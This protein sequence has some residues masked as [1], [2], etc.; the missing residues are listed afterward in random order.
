MKNV[1]DTVKKPV[2]GLDDGRAKQKA[3]TRIPPKHD[4]PARWVPWKPER[5][6]PGKGMRTK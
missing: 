6:I 4:R 3:P 5:G 1:R 2:G